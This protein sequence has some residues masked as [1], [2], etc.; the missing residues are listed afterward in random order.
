MN[1]KLF[2]TA[3]M[4]SQSIGQLAGFSDQCRMTFRQQ[5]AKNLLGIIRDAF[6]YILSFPANV[7]VKRWKWTGGER[8]KMV[9][10]QMTGNVR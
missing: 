3:C 7:F 9:I 5:D 10:K 2:L 4:A 8:M 6:V 1:T